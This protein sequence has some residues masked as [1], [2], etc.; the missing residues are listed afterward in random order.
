[1]SAGRLGTAWASA[2]AAGQQAEPAAEE[3]R[4]GWACDTGKGG[5][6]RCRPA[7]SAMQKFT[8]SL[9]LLSKPIPSSP[10]CPGKYRQLWCE[11]SSISRIWDYTKPIFLTP[12]NSLSPEIWLQTYLLQFW[13]PSNP[14]ITWETPST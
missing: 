11:M 13:E 12:F 7:F 6:P 14:L 8:A 10:H 4:P 3:T 1:V 5:S 9:L 2:P